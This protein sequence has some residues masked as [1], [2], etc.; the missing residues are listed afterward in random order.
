MSIFVA[1]ALARRLTR[2]LRASLAISIG[3]SVAQSQV[4]DVAPAYHPK[5]PTAGYVEVFQGDPLRLEFSLPGLDHASSPSQ[6]AN[7]LSFVAMSPAVL[8]GP[9]PLGPNAALWLNP[10]GLVLNPIPPTFAI[11]ASISPPASGGPIDLFLQSAHVRLSDASLWTSPPLHLQ[12][13]PAPSAGATDVMRPRGALAVGA[14]AIW[15][16]APTN[17]YRLRWDAPGGAD[18]VE[19]VLDLDHPS[20]SQGTLRVL[21]KHSGLEVLRDGGIYYV[22]GFGV[23]LWSP[24]QFESQ[25]THVLEA[26]GQSGSTI[27]F[28]WRDEA[29]KLGGGVSVHRRRH[30]FTLHGRALEVRVRGLDPS[31]GQAGDN[32]FGWTLGLVSAQQ[33]QPVPSYEKVHLAYMDQ[34]GITLV[35]DDWF[36]S[37]FID[38]F[39]SNAAQHVPALFSQLGGQ[40]FYSEQMQYTRAS[41]NTISL[42]D[43]SGWVGVSRDVTDLFVESSAPPSPRVSQLARRVAVT[44]AGSPEE[45]A[46]YA[47]EH[48]KLKQLR[49]FGFDDVYLMKF[50][51]MRF[52]LNRRA[53]THVPPNPLGGTAQQMLDTLDEGLDAGWRCALYTDL[54]SL[55][56]AVG[57]DDNP[58]YSETPGSYENFEDGLKLNDLSYRKGFG[59]SID[60]SQPGSGIY[61]SRILAPRRAQ[62]HWER[63]AQTFVD[64]YGTNAA[65]F[66]INCISAPDLITTASGQNVGG[67]LSQDARSPSD[68]TLRGAIRSYKSLYQHAGERTGGATV[69]EGS[70]SG[71]ETRFDT[72]Y[73]GYL[74][75]TYRTLS[76]GGAPAFPAT[77]GQ[78]QPIMPDY[79][80]FCVRGKHYGFGLG[81]PSRFFPIGF[82]Y[83]LV[84]A[85]IQEYRAT[86]I[87]YA[88]NGFLMT[89][90]NLTS[91]GE[92]KTIPEQVKEYYLFRSLQDEWAAATIQ[93]VR[94]R[95]GSSG[96]QWQTLSQALKSGLDLKV[97]V[98]RQ[99]W[100]NGLVVVVSHAP[101]PVTEEGVVLPT[102]GWIARNPTTGYLN[103]ATLDPQTGTLVHR[104]LAPSYMLA[105]GNGTQFTCGGAIGQT[106]D[107]SVVRYDT[108]LALV[109]NLDGSVEVQ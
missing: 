107:L 13:L 55:D 63:E 15:Y 64:V 81:P 3:I 8:P 84:D 86:Q 5:G 73:A 46:S 61:H 80:L 72:F 71:F 51:W 22:Q 65:Y 59:M 94:Y 14:S 56:Q 52:G 89:N 50:H 28:E 20:F 16:D 48:L 21:E 49:S 6:A 39:R 44:L 2:A 10:L 7:W 104:V 105:D 18:W 42:L 11:N 96:A 67:A 34:I 74:D 95:E 69:G 82:T 31:A 4:I 30:E 33:G 47:L 27:W 79:E 99:E 77:S 93:S 35:N 100:S 1:A 36:H 103:S 43:E 78:A 60:L 76:T 53:S 17:D 26:H 38:L 29:P 106:K 83:P 45:G 109:E 66:D 54:F 68:R 87:S 108:G 23:N 41:D 24:Q 12:A 32:Y 90:G 97:P 25:A 57:F 37:A 9:L 102:H 85:Q 101:V 98:L 62:K 58:N 70:F 92:Y 19:Y 75:G 88:F 40:A 91:V